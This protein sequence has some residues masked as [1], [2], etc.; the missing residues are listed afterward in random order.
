MFKH[1][2]SFE[3]R[4]WLKNWAFY[5]YL[6][7][8]FVLSFF[9]M[10]GAV[11]YFDSL[12]VTT[13]SMTYMNSPIGVNEFLTGLNQILYFLFP[14][15]IGAGIYRDF[16][17]EAHHILYSYPFTKTDYLLGKFLSAFTATFIISLVIGLG[18]YLATILP[19]ANQSLLTT[20]HLWSY[21]QA[22]LFNVIP[23]ML[24][25]GIIVFAVTTLSRSV[26][27]GFVAVLA[28]LILQGV[29][30]GLSRDMDNKI[31]VALLDPSGAA[32]INYYTEY[33]TID[34]VNHNNLPLQKWF[35]LNRLIW[36]GISGLFLV[37][38]GR[39]FKFSQQAVSFNWFKKKGE[40]VTKDNF[41]GLF[42]IELPKV[43][44]DFSLSA[45]LKNLWNFT[46]IDFKHLAKNKVFMI[47]AGLGILLMVSIASTATAMFGTS[48][49]PV[50]NIMLDLPGSTFS[51]VIIVITFLGAG[52][53][54]HRGELSRMNHL[55]DA[56]AVPNWVL[57]ASKYLALILIQGT[58]LLVIMAGG[59]LIQ[60]YNQYYQFEIDLYL[61]SLL[62][63]E[64]VRY[65][66]WAGLALAVQTFFKNYIVGFFVLLLFYMFGGQISRLGIEQTIFFFNRLPSPSYSNMNGYGSSLPRY[67]IYAFYWLLFIGFLSGLT[68]LF[69]RRGVVGGIKERWFYAKKRMKPVVV[70]PAL[71]CLFGFLALGGYLYYEN[72]VMHPYYS[73]KE[74][75]QMRV[76]FEKK[77]KKY[78]DMAQP[79][80]TDVKVDLDLY[81]K[82][83]DFEARG[84]FLM[85]NKTGVAIDSLLVNLSDSYISEIEI[86][87]ADLKWKDTLY[88]LSVYKFRQP[89]DSGQTVQLSFTI[90]NKPNTVL[91]S[92]SP[93]MYNG[94]FMNN[95]YF[96]SL[97][98]SSGREI[99]DTETRKKYGLPPKER[100][101]EQTDMKARQNTYISDDAD[102]ITFETTVSTSED[103][104]AIA[105]GYLQKEWTENGRRYFHYSMGEQKI[106][107]FYAFNSARYEVVK[108][109]WK[110]INLEIY[111]H[112]GHEY[113]L[114]RMMNGLKKGFDYFTKEFSPFQF[115]QMRI[116]EFPSTMGTFAQSFANTVPFSE[117]IGFI[118]DVD[119]EDE[120]A[121]DYPFSVTAHELA[122]QW[123]AHQVIGANVQ[124]AT[125]LS[126]SLA[127]YSSLKV[128]EHEY[129]KGQMRKFLKDA[130]DRYLM[131]RRFESKKEK[132]L[133]YNENQQYIHYNKGSLV[134]YALS[135]Y[136]GEQNM[137]KVLSEYIDEVAFQYP[138]YTTAGELVEKL[139]AAA[140]DSL[141]YLIHDM[142]E[143]ITLYDNYVEK[144]DY[145]ELDNGKYEVNIKA[146]I[147]K[148]HAD[149]RGKRLYAD[150]KND[151]LVATNDKDK[152]VKSLPLNDY[153]E[154]GVFGEKDT[155][156]VKGKSSGE[157][158]LY[159]E[160]LKVTE[161]NND[162][163]IIVDEKPVEVGV[164]PY[165]MLID[166]KSS[167]NRKK[168]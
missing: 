135:E 44:Y 39:A 100:M 42:K 163:K 20:N 75:E 159:L 81:P 103:Q 36:I 162:F 16:K 147:S 59:I 50:T 126:E 132:P 33:W 115:K 119:D 40:R 86:D 152:E 123:W 22:Y 87:R 131:S 97:G 5:L 51:L 72:T 118:A 52:L 150:V 73:A 67:F 78:E 113:N 70:V 144:A 55:I 168:L 128:L 38:L 80:I 153:I 110:D 64:W 19:W 48:I 111:Y 130:L 164:D 151:S 27:V 142:F 154:V 9:M 96:P 23:N 53:L 54:V 93:V 166:T 11:G 57:F 13:S 109:K 29:L 136:M 62:G 114:D 105:P 18:M 94:T 4:G 124:G 122:H 120:N 7:I 77:Y 41:V 25:I 139:K 14:T 58:L 31:M 137:N 140:P 76:D 66:I 121:V 89:L 127:E 102:W 125:M 160:K 1:I 145:K 82:T 8:F 91:R 88:G 95:M 65:I 60:A 21:A 141:Q 108:D 143:T 46:K 116:L 165:N 149:E 32:A 24:L 158:I 3:L 107:N 92:N 43:N 167:D 156:N 98:Y 133:M 85:E 45:Q 79:R 34:E 47:L 17:Y 10:A 83:R 28:I 74:R 99:A 63:I 134:F 56:T 104:I 69:W 106:L 84:K 112:K 71:I 12:V 157:K 26:Y 68:A 15:I 61:K 117:G 49:L 146:V 90:K 35:L 129:G 138:P 30:A 155:D 148:Y 101:A 161:I 2:F 37:L 6:F